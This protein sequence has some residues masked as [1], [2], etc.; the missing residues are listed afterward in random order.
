MAG[1]RSSGW[2]RGNAPAPDYVAGMGE[3][4]GYL[5]L[6]V[7]VWQTD[8]V[9]G[10]VG[11]IRSRDRNRYDQSRSLARLT[12]DLQNAIYQPDPFL[13]TDKAEPLA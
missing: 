3:S 2:S 5:R 11:L 6:G 8:I 9:S 13:D 4:L 7:V 12:F 1:F 10:T